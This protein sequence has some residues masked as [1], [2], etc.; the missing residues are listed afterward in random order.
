M[1]VPMPQ[2]TI[3]ITHGQLIDDEIHTASTRS[4]PHSI[5][6]QPSA[7]IGPVADLFWK[8]DQAAG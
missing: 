7:T 3:N 8:S 1:S 6:R 2:T 4:H 5:Q